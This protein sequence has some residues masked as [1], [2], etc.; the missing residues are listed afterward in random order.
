MPDDLEAQTLK[1][2]RNVSRRVTEVWFPFIGC[3]LI[4]CLM[5]VSTAFVVRIANP[6]TA[7][8]SPV[9][10]AEFRET[11]PAST[12]HTQNLIVDL[13]SRTATLD[14]VT[15][16]DDALFSTRRAAASDGLNV[17]AGGGGQ[18]GV[19]NVIGTYTASRNVSYGFNALLN[20]VDG[21]DNI[22]IGVDSLKNLIGI[23]AG[24][25]ANQGHDNIC[26]GDHSCEADLIGETNIGIGGNALSSNQLSRNSVAIGFNALAASTA[27]E[28]LAFGTNSMLHMVSGTQNISIG[29]TFVNATAGNDNIVMGHDSLGGCTVN[30]NDNLALGVDVLQNNDSIQN[31]GLG[32][33]ALRVATQY[34]NVGVGIASGFTLT[35]GHDSTFVGTSTGNGIT[36][37]SM[38][39]IVGANVH[40]LAGAT[41]AKIILADG[42]TTIADYLWFDMHVPTSVNHGA[43]GTGS[44]NTVGNVTGVGA[45]TSVTLTYSNS[46][47]P[48]RSW[49][50]AATN[51]HTGLVEVIIVT[52]SATAPVFSC[53]AATTGAASNCEDFTYWCTGQ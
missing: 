43:L 33:F 49:C 15:N 6:P 22:A 2:K 45:N 27:Q 38:N 21:Y 48:H 12:F 29:T 28:N 16:G 24:L 50:Q 26:I 32:T 10:R 4:A 37:G 52:N 18:L 53:F 17:F 36:T 14:L 8:A 25:G 41:E 39:T 42:D 7:I 40:G 44:S 51:T 3:V 19:V 34:N 13:N 11:W 5:S 46:G 23:N 20:N 35:S 9:S 30:C 31:V 47:F 1:L